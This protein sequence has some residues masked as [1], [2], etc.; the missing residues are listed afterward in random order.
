M[1]GP[2]NIRGIDYQVWC[3]LLLVLTSLTEGEA[4]FTHLQ[5][6]SLDDEGEDLAFESDHGRRVQVQIKKMVEGYN[7]TPAT[8]R[9]TLI[10]FA[11]Y[12]ATTESLFLSDGSASR[13]LLPLKK[14]LEGE[15]EL[16]ADISASVCDETFSVTQ[17]QSL[18]GRVRIQTRHFPSPIEADPAARVRMEVERLIASG[19][20]SV[21][22]RPAETASRLWE[23]LFAAAREGSLLSRTDLVR[24]FANAGLRPVQSH[25]AV[26]PIADKYY[27]HE[28]PVARASELLRNGGLV[29][30]TGI[31]G[32][33]KS[34]FLAEAASVAA[35]SGCVFRS[36][37]ATPSD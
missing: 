23:T 11:S 34:T 24:E 3:S 13:Q 18:A 32:S 5:V 28:Y 4:G 12:P 31:G 20:F 37:A 22:S 16:D 8:L 15:T 25:W 27:E 29:S 19:R 21:V 1:S 9:S 14:F 33:G 7:W 35:Q 36:N 17:L 2:D 26:Y 6:E 30:V 10:R